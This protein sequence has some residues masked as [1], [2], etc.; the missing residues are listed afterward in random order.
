MS[1]ISEDNDVQL[2]FIS[3]S[4]IFLSTETFRINHI[5]SIHPCDSFNP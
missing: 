2:L 5:V 1:I 3:M 4:A